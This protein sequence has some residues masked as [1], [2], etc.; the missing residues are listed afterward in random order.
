MKAGRKAVEADDAAYERVAAGMLAP[1][2]EK[3][4]A[5][6]LELMGKIEG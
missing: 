1:L 3:E 5:T 2:T 6:L 4:Q